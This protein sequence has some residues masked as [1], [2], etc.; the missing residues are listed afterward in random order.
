[1]SSITV[2]YVINAFL[3]ANSNLFIRATLKLLLCKDIP[4]WFLRDIKVIKIPMPSYT[5]LQSPS[6]KYLEYL[7]WLVV[8]NNTSIRSHMACFVWNRSSRQLGEYQGTWLWYYFVKLFSLVRNL[9]TFSQSDPVFCN[10]TSNAREFE[11]SVSSLANVVRLWVSAML[12]GIQYYHPVVLISSS[13]IMNDYFFYKI[14]EEYER[15]RYKEKKHTT[16]KNP[17]EK[18]ETHQMVL[19]NF[20][21]EV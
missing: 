2:E 20:R 12:I 7:Q 16:C 19:Q 15:H 11:Q 4:A 18:E 8:M 10:P 6:K 17:K 3:R 13:L 14:L 5:A 21:F 1:M 9:Q